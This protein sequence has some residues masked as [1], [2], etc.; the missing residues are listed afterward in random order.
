MKYVCVHMR[1][2]HGTFVDEI[3][4]VFHYCLVA[5]FLSLI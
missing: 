4:L 2:V 5:G 3:Q 1:F